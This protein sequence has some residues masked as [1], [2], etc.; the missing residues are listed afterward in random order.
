MRERIATVGPIAAV[1]GA[2]G[3]CCGLPVLFSLGVMGAITGLSVQNWALI[4]LGLGLAALGWVRILRRPRGRRRPDRSSD[5][6]GVVDPVAAATF[7]ITDSST[8]SNRE[9]HS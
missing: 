5:Q 6:P 7:R 4:G 3:L 9:Y 1:A 2:L 8:D